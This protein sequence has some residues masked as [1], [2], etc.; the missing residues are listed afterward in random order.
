MGSRTDEA[1]QRVRQQRAL[2]ERKVEGLEGRVGAD[3]STARE[4]VQH[5]VTHLPEILPGGS[6]V[7]DQARDHPMAAV[8]S[9]LGVG[10]AL[11]LMTGSGSDEEEE[12][13]SRGRGRSNGASAFGAAGG[14]L[15]GLG[16]SMMSPLAPYLQDM[17]RDVFS[18]FA[19]RN[20]QEAERRAREDGHSPSP[21]HGS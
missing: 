18:G 2:I 21:A 13:Y 12:R 5:H 15:S 19:D 9:S 3:L 1:E 14:M 17:A 4:R 20:R 10:V 7:M 16:A 6:Q 8:A 11:G